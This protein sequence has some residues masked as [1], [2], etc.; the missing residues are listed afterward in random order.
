MDD[1]QTGIRLVLKI[2]R[3][4]SAYCATMDIP[5]QGFTNQPIQTMVFLGDNTVF[6]AGS[7]AGDWVNFKATLNDPATE[8]SGNW[9]NGQEFFPMTFRRSNGAPPA[10]GK[11]R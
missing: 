8:L 3:T 1:G 5:G 7:F 6:L 9:Q 4:N 11:A 2:S 10:T